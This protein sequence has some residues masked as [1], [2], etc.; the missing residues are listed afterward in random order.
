MNE[1]NITRTIMLSLSKLGVKIFRNNTAMGFAGQSKR[2]SKRE[3]VT[4]EA[5]DI[6]IRNGTVLHSGLC[7]GSSDLIGYKS[8]TVTPEMIGKKLA[9]F[10]ACEVKTPS[11]RATPEQ[12]AFINMVNEH[13]G[14]GFIARSADEACA[15]ICNKV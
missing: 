12:I 7:K 13:G 3:T 6:I 11:G 2:F 5:G 9:I 4:L 8:V 10:T 14:I 15:A 1:T